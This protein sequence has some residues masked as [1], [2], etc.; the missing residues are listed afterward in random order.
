MTLLR[1]TLR[2]SSGDRFQ[3]EPHDH[4]SSLQA[5]HLA[6]FTTNPPPVATDSSERMLIGLIM[7]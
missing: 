6:L 1:E 4:I 3:N 7:F 2:G 5:E